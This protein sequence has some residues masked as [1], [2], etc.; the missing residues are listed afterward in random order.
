[1]KIEVWT[2]GSA[3]TIDKP[4]GWAY[5]LVVDDQFHSEGS[6]RWENATNN[7]M[8]L[9]AAIEGLSAVYKI[10]FPPYDISEQMMAVAIPPPVYAVE[11]I[12]CA[13]SQLVLGWASGEYRFKQEDKIEKYRELR[14]MVNKMNVQTKWIRGHSGHIWNERCDKLA[15][16]ARLGIKELDK[17]HPMMDTRIGIKKKGTASLWYAGKLKVVDFDLGII[18]DYNREVHGKRGSVIEIREEKTR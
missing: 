2:D 13:D 15:N 9:Q 11:T 10:L 4:G 8:E 6:G 16:N 7:D 14:L 3:Q 5:V 18:E 1:M 12:L 17:S